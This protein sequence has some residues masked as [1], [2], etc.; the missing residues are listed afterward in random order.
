MK[1]LSI[2][3]VLIAHVGVLYPFIFKSVVNLFRY[4]TFGVG[5]DL[6]FCISGYVVAR[7]YCDYFDHYRGRGFGPTPEDQQV[8]LEL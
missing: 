4:A 1:L 6:F 2:L 3:F 5:V 8:M 7:A